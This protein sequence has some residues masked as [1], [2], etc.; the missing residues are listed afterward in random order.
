MNVTTCNELIGQCQEQTGCHIRDSDPHTGRI[1][2]SREGQLSRRQDL[3]AAAVFGDLGA[4]GQ[5]TVWCDPPVVIGLYVELG[6][7]TVTP[8]TAGKEAE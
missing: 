8:A 2:L 5:I 6:V 3:M 1:R 7:L 4:G